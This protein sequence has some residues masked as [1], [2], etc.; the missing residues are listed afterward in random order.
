[1]AYIPAALLHCPFCGSAPVRRD[2]RDGIGAGDAI[3]RFRRRCVNKDCPARPCVT[4]EGEAGY[5]A[6]TVRP[7]DEAA[8]LADEMWNTRLDKLEPR[9][10]DEAG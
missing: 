6:N 4:V 2:S 3:S 9:R 10:G 7:N 1:M 8:R 5:T